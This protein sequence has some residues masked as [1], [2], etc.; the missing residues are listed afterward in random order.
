VPAQIG[1]RGINPW[2]YRFF[3]FFIRLII[4]GK[5]KWSRPVTESKMVTSPS[6]STINLP[7]KSKQLAA[8]QLPKGIE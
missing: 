1:F 2:L 7:G 5:K 4:F 6:K 3:F 8:V